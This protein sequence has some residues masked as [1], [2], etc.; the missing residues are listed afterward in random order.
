[1]DGSTFQDTLTELEKCIVSIGKQDRWTETIPADWA[2]SEIVLRELKGQGKKIALVSELSENVF[3]SNEAKHSQISDVLKFYHDIG[4]ILRFNESL[5]S[6]T[7]II[8]IQWFVDS[9]KNIITDPNNVRDCAEDYD[10]WLEFNKNGH[11]HDS[12]LS[13]IWSSQHFEIASSDRLNLLQYM[14][15]LGLIVIGEKAHYIPCMN[16]RSFSSEQENDLNSIERKTSVLVFR[17]PFLPYF[18]YFRLIVAC[19]TQTGGK[20]AILEDN[21]LK[22][23]FK[24]VACF[25]FKKHTVVLAVNKYSIQVQVFQSSRIS[26]MKDVTLEIRQD[27]EQLL[28]SITSKFHKNVIYTVGYQCS[29]QE[30][31]RGHDDCFVKEIEIHGKEWISCPRHG[32]HCCHDVNES[33]LLLF[34]WNKVF[35]SSIS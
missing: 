26:I 8:D 33:D 35:I 30:V 19:L 14:E 9:F 23:L 34:Y 12:L 27:I 15:R 7:V 4:V 24:N 17:F 28:E 16:K 6:N 29:K 22:C 20:W 1:M 32:L 31:F 21:A 11:L 25:V 10:D 13:S 3:G 2:L 5:L 18:F